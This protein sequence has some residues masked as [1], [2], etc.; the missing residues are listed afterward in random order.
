[1]QLQANAHK[2]IYLC[3]TA[4]IIGFVLSFFVTQDLRRT[5]FGEKKA[6]TFKEMVDIELTVVE[7]KQ[8]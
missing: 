3:V 4:C 5:N 7:E 8:N 2:V 6:G 1:M